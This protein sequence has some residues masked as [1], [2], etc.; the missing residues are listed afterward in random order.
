MR[1]NSRSRAGFEQPDPFAGSYDLTDP[2]SFNR[3]AYVQNDPVNF[4][5]PSGLLPMLVCGWWGSEGFGE[6]GAG[7]GFECVIVDLPRPGQGALGDRPPTGGGQRNPPTL[8]EV[9]K[10][11]EKCL[12][13]V[14]H[15]SDIKLESFSPASKGK[16]GSA[17][18]TW[19]KPGRQDVTI[20]TSVGSNARQLAGRAALAGMPGGISTRFHRADGPRDELRRQRHRRITRPQQQATSPLRRCDRRVIPNHRGP[21]PRRAYARVNRLHLCVYVGGAPKDPYAVETDLDPDSGY[22]LGKCTVRELTGEGGKT[23]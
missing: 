22:R 6:S 8:K 13:E 9:L 5:D 18:A 17:R 3:Y 15:D 14:F 2:Q 1:R 10:A 7:R 11:L 23:K 21:L 19:S 16:D 4:V 20:K 12:K